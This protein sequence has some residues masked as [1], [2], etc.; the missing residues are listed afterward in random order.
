MDNI[1]KIAVSKIAETLTNGILIR[2]ETDVWMKILFGCGQSDLYDDHQYQLNAVWEGERDSRC[3]I[4]NPKCYEALRTILI[5]IEGQGEDRFAK[6]MSTI[7]K[8]IKIERIFNDEGHK[9]ATKM[10]ICYSIEEYLKRNT[11]EKNNE[12]LERYGHEDYKTFRNNMNLL[13]FDVAFS[14]NYEELLI[15]PLFSSIGDNVER[16][17]VENWLERKYPDVYSSYIEAIDT[18]SGGNKEACL[19]MCRNVIT[20]FFTYEKDIGYK[21]MS[22]LKNCCKDKNIE[23]VTPEFIIKSSPNKPNDEIA[24]KRYN[25]PRFRL[26]YQLYSYLSDLGPHANEGDIGEFGPNCEQPTQTDALLGLK[27]TQD[28]LTWLYKSEIHI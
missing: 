21:W 20:G 7:V 13:E 15:Q 9:H 3:L 23:N 8:Y 22:G 27:V 14:S 28:V 19:S 12:L 5:K 11:L 10:H 16:S 24:D 4:H 26:I 25:Y 18:F 1:F 2:A 17:A 6:I